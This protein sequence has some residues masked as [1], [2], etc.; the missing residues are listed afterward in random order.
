MHRAQ[1]DDIGG[2]MRWGTLIYT[3]SGYLQEVQA[4][5]LLCCCRSPLRKDGQLI[6]IKVHFHKIL[7]S[8]PSHLGLSET[9]ALMPCPLMLGTPIIYAFA[10]P[11]SFTP[12]N[13][14]PPTYAFH[15][16]AIP[17]LLDGQSGSPTSSGPA[18]NLNGTWHGIWPY[19]PR[20]GFSIAHCYALSVKLQ[21][22]RSWQKIPLLH[23]SLG[24]GTAMNVAQS[25]PHTSQPII[26]IHSFNPL[27]PFVFI[28]H[29]YPLKPQPH[30]YWAY[31]VSYL[32]AMFLGLIQHMGLLA[33]V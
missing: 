19:D 2:T 17:L 1:W 14:S 16:K 32:S 28:T 23:F 3:P 6:A 12:P 24:E 10:L 27:P 4:A 20:L 29:P 5:V 8:S 26:S 7:K 22:F 33:T 30:H 9:L 13:T 15:P 21:R 11:N 18:Q 25:D 31:F